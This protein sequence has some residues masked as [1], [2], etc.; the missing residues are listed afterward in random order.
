MG[1]DRDIDRI[2]F[3][4]QVCDARIFSHSHTGL[5]F[6]PDAQKLLDLPVQHF[7]R[8]AVIRDSVP[9][10]SAQFFP[11]LQYRHIMPHQAE[12]VGC[13]DAAGTAADHSYPFSGSNSRHRKRHISCM[14]YCETLQSPDVHRI[15]H[16]RPAAAH[17]AGMLADQAADSRHGII[18]S[19]E[20][21]GI[22]VAS[23]RYQR[24]ISRNIHSG[25][26]L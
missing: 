6:D 15:V 1:A 13:A 22:P 7:S 17:F 14:V 19:Y 3:F 23:F 5:Y 26:A 4:P 12:I 10:H 20:A 9:E 11:L 18:L 2:V 21:D 8:K 16:H 24:N 25:R